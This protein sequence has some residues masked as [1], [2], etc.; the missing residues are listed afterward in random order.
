MYQQSKDSKW[1][2]RALIVDGSFFSIGVAF[3]ESNTIFPALISQL[4]TNSVLIGLMS[5]IRNAG[6]LLPQL[7]VAG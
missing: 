1:N 3:L 4:T 6:Y 7:F 5:T 2:F